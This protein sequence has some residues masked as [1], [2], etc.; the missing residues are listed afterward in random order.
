MRQRRA[1]PAR[2]LRPAHHA[3]SALRKL[4]LLLPACC[5]ARCCVCGAA[6]RCQLLAPGP[7]QQCT[8]QSSLCSERDAPHTQVCC[9]PPVQVTRP[10]PG[11][12]QHSK[13]GAHS[14]CLL[15][16]VPAR[17]AHRS[18][19]AAPRTTPHTP[20]SPLRPG[21]HDWQLQP[22]WPGWQLVGLPCRRQRLARC[23]APCHA[24][25]CR[26]GIAKSQPHNA[27]PRAVQQR[28]M[29]SSLPH[30]ACGTDTD[31]P[32]QGAAACAVCV[33]TPAL[34]APQAMQSPSDA[35]AAFCVPLSLNRNL[36]SRE[37]HHAVPLWRTEAYDASRC[38]HHHH[39]SACASARGGPASVC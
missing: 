4:A 34:P 12:G 15:L 28:R 26:G 22:C 1:P 19:A 37:H 14:S 11:G 23:G 18:H 38:L 8:A 33:G 36:H 13:R 39:R 17:A 6:R 27:A 7:G 20:A 9:A 32:W 21:R 30:T 10:G 31:A 16:A 25:P 5:H 35:S 2:T 29:G 24:M 3:S